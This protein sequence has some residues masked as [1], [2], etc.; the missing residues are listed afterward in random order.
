[1]AFFTRT[2][3]ATGVG[4]E[5]MVILNNGNVGVGT[6][7]PVSQFQVNGDAQR[8]SFGNVPQANR[9]TMGWVTQYIGFNLSRETSGW[10]TYS[11]GVNNGAS[12]IL[13]DPFGNLKIVNVS[14]SGNSTRYLTETQINDNTKFIISPSGNVG[15]GTTALD[16]KLTVKGNMH[17]EEVKVD[18]SVPGPDYV[19]EKDYALPTLESVK[20]YI[21]QNKHLPEVPSAKEMEAKGINLSEMNMLLLKKVEELTLYVIEMN[22]VNMELIQQTKSLQNQIE[23]IKNE[24]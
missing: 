8:T 2:A 24:K 12:M 15:V 4:T 23:E 10:S 17:A 22:K 7:S 13:A 11:D 6:T 9:Q 5:K 19:F 14:S 20:T 3:G 21:D 16:A 18:L 1:M